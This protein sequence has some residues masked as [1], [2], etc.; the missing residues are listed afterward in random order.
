MKIRPRTAH[1][2]AAA[3]VEFAV[4][5]PLLVALFMF[6]FDFC[7]IYYYTIVLENCAQNAALFGSQS[8]D[9]QNQQ[10]VGGQQYWQGP[11]GQLLTPET[12]ATQ[13]D[14]GNL[15]PALT[16]SNINVQSGTDTDGHTVKIVTITY[17]FN[18]I[19]SFPGI[20]SAVTIVRTAQVRVAPANPS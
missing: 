6:T 12:V 9:N 1:R 11:S 15:T 18:T 16:A 4:L 13:L 3:V 19:V 2:R 17:T 7:R 5:L 20:P 10:W 14:G 8:F